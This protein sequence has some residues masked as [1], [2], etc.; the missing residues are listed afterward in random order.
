MRTAGAPCVSGSHF[1]R[2]ARSSSPAES[3]PDAEHGL[4][5]SRG[6]DASPELDL[7]LY[8]NQ[9]FFQILNK[10]ERCYTIIPAHGLSISVRIS[11]TAAAPLS[12][13]CQSSLAIFSCSA[14]ASGAEVI[15]ATPTRMLG[16]SPSRNGLSAST[17]RSG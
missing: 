6:D 10:A 3:G 13:R 8:Q 12:A 14:S 7:H 15:I 5:P 16:C 4:L 9:Y 2:C 17:C 1:V 11:R